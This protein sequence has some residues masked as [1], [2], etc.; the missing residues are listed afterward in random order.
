[1]NLLCVFSTSISFQGGGN[2]VST[3]RKSYSLSD[4]SEPDMHMDMQRSHD[5]VDEIV[6]GR[7][8]HIIQYR[9]SM[10]PNQRHAKARMQNANI[11]YSNGLNRSSST[12]RTVDVYYDEMMTRS[13]DNYE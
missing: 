3:L 5:E 10:Q 9:H 1:M 4:L 7:A 13:S 12:S 11:S 8:N 2:L 6:Y